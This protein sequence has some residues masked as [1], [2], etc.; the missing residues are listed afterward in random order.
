MVGV[1]FE[2][3]T[4]DEKI[5]VLT[6][7]REQEIAKLES[8]YNPLQRKISKMQIELY[9]NSLIKEVEKEEMQINE[10]RIR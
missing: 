8:L 4:K 3:L 1:D 6:V 7:R 5:M 2:S 10:G 9:Y